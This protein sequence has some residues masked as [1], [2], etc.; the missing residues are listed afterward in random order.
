MIPM[1]RQRSG[2]NLFISCRMLDRHE[3]NRFFMYLSST[4]GS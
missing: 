1:S 3:R 2:E 4:A